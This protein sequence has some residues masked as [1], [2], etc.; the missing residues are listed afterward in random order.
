MTWQGGKLRRDGA[1]MPQF[2]PLKPLV[3]E[4]QDSASGMALLG[5]ALADYPTRLSLHIRLV[6]GE[7]GEA[8][9]HWGVQVGSESSTPTRKEPTDPNVIVVMRPETWMQIAQGRL[10]P[11]E[12]LYTGRLRVGGD[13]EAAKA[14]ARF[15]S[16]PAS[17][18][19]APC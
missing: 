2:A 10:A 3:G 15:L 13:F 1:P 17:P 11:Y 14:I 16:D 8:V 5:R 4:L 9:E 18:Y 7:E 12:A 6:S 19:V